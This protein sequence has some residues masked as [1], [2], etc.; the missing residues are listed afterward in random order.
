MK[1]IFRILFISFS[2]SFI[3]PIPDANARI[4]LKESLCQEFWGK[5]LSTF[6]SD[7]VDSSGKAANLAGLLRKTIEESLS[8]RVNIDFVI[9]DARDK[10]DIAIDCDIKELV[11]D[12]GAPPESASAGADKGIFGL[13][14]RGAGGRVEAVFTV[15]DLR[16]K[17]MLWQKRLMATVNAKEGSDMSPDE[18]LCERLTQIFV[19]E[20]FARKK[21]RAAFPAREGDPV[22]SY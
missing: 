10:A 17:R 9:V 11:W 18:L 1:V 7:P 5:K 21:L 15:I 4:K 19:K 16:I 14:G 3:L 6:V 13:F 8:T 12:G 2:V 22:G 20:C